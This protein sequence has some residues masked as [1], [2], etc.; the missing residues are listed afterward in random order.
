MLL[1]EAN[2]SRR[3]EYYKTS[4][5]RAVSEGRAYKPDRTL[6][7]G[8]PPDVKKVP[9]WDLFY[10]ASGGTRTHCPQFRKLLLYPDELRRRTADFILYGFVFC[11]PEIIKTIF[12]KN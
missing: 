8:L 7:R 4:D 3:N 5:R 6:V 11:K 2:D 1:N 10:G 12:Q 9:L